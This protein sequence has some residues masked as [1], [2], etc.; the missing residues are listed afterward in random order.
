MQVES[1][2]A[3]DGLVEKVGSARRRNDEHIAR[4]R[5]QAL[6]LVA[7]LQHRRT[8]LVHAA[9]VLRQHAPGGEPVHVVDADDAWPGLR[10]LLE[11]LADAGGP[12][13]DEDLDELRTGNEERR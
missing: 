9:F 5:L 4:K 13:A 12:D 10:G 7:Q 1:P 11:D 2:R 6:E 3:R 8:A